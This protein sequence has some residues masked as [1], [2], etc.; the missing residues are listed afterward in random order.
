MDGIYLS[1]LLET[2]VA[3]AAA[4]GIGIKDQCALMIGRLMIN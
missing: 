3:A 1:A 2:G 4:I